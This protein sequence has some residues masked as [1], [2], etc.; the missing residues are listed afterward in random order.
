MTGIHRRETDSSERVVSAL[1]NMK[2]RNTTLEQDCEHLRAELSALNDQ[3]SALDAK[4]QEINSRRAADHGI[5]L[6]NRDL[7]C[8]HEEDVERLIDLKRVLEQTV[9]QLCN[10]RKR[11]EQVEAKTV[12]IAVN[13]RS[14]AHVAESLQPKPEKPKQNDTL[15]RRIEENKS[16][17]NQQKQE[18]QSVLEGLRVKRDE[19]VEELSTAS[20]R[21]RGPHRTARS[22]SRAEK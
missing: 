22:E 3:K 7:Q 14:L 9:V 16:K 19:F 15:A 8:D 5:E 4:L 10:E 6:E 20:R 1:K 2:R 18:L 21:P 13:I 17:W 11:R 12:K